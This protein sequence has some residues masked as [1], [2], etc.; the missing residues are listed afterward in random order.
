MAPY[1]YLAFDLGAESG[2]V[3]LAL[4]ENGRLS[5]E[6]VY[7]FPNEPVH[8]HGELHWDVLRLWLEMLRGLARLR[9]H[10]IGELDGIGVDTWGVDFALLGE[11]GTLLQNPYHYRDKGTDGITEK[12]FQ[13][14]APETIY[15]RTGVQFMQINSL[16]QLYAIAARTPA[17]L[18]TAERFLM[19]PDLFNF[20]LTGVTVSEF[21]N[22]TTTQMFD[23]R[24]GHWAG[25]ILEKLGLPS[26]ILPSVVPP[27]T[28]LGPL[29]GELL[30]HAG[31][32]RAP[33]IAPACHDTGS[34]VAAIASHSRSAFI[35]SGTW[36]LMG[37]EVPQPVITPGA[38]LLNFTNEGGVAGTFRLLKNITGMWLLQG[39]R[40]A[41]QSDGKDLS[42]E[43]MT[44]MVS[45]DPVLESLINPNDP[46]FLHPD[47]MQE[48]IR[49]FCARTQ[50]P[51]PSEPAAFVQTILESLA[52]AYKFVLGSIEKLTGERMEI[53][54]VVGGGAMNKV[55]NQMIADATNRPVFAGP[56]EATALGNVALQ[57]AATG[58]VASLSQARA[59][60]NESF[61]PEEYRPRR[62][63][64]WDRAYERFQHYMNP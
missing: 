26:H 25:D 52:L 7:R 62:A 49:E 31:L 23:P 16:Y 45:T 50:Q 6:E 28:V 58:A 3:L 29:R 54:R 42:Y 22:A 15:D 10:G 33:V 1:R 35:S 13:T 64:P 41:W 39:C 51:L 19:I 8:A 34:A 30:E 37:T 5:M 61:P 12:V 32:S 56:V 27:G 43:A 44:A 20:W 14:V 46:C 18:K 48:A 17:L 60:I 38:R 53:I 9:K 47:N 57:M 40:R 63:E 11:G 55:L 36:S 59:V 2:R 24:T 21:T 4:F